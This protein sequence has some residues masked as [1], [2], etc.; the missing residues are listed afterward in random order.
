MEKYP[1]IPGR[2]LVSPL[3]TQKRIDFLSD[4]DMVLQHIKNHNLA[5]RDIQNKIESFVGS[6]EVP[7]GLIGPIQFNENGRSE[8]IYSVA[9]TLEGALVASINRGAKAITLSGGFSADFLHQR[10]ER[11]PM[12][13][14]ANQADADHFIK[15]CT[16]KFDAIKKVAESHSNHAKLKE[17]RPICIDKAVHLKFLYT[18]G[19]A[20]GQNMTTTCTW[21]AVK[22]IVQHFYAATQILIE[23][24]L[25][26]GNGSSDKK[27]SRYILEEGRGSCVEASCFLSDD[28]IQKVLRT[29]SERLVLFYEN[30]IKMAQESGMLGFN[31]NIANVI[32]ALFLA[33]GQDM[34]SVHESSLGWFNVA[35]AKNGVSLS[36]KL[37]SLV[38]GSIGGGTGLP[39]QKEVLEL[40][41]CYGKGKVQRFAKCIAGFALALEISTFGAVV[42]GEFAKAHEKLGRNRP[43]DFLSPA[44]ID[45]E[46]VKS[47]LHDPLMTEHLKRVAVEHITLVENGML[48][49]LTART[50]KKIMGFIPIRLSLCEGERQTN[51][52]LL[53]KSK[54]LDVD[55]YNGLHK[56]ACAIDIKLAD[57]L[58]AYRK[59]LEYHRCHLKE[60]AIYEALAESGLDVSPKFYDKKIDAKREIYV[61][62]LEF[63][64]KENLSIYDSENR[65]D[66]WTS[67]CIEK[68]ITTL[69]W[70]H[71]KLYYAHTKGR[72]DSV[73]QFEVKKALPFYERLIRVV[74]EEEHYSTRAIL[75][76]ELSKYLRDLETHLAGLKLPLTVIHNDFNPRNIAIRKDGRLAIYDW[77]LS[78]VNLPHRDVVELL[79][80]VLPEDFGL[81]QME[82]YLKLHHH[83]A[84]GNIPWNNW[85]QGYQRALKEYLV[86]RVLFYKAAN[87]VM[88]LKFIDRVFRCTRRMLQLLND[89]P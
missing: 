11:A 22:W 18:T 8:L 41:G 40:M 21:H 9:A 51:M 17:I 7:V 54:G 36:L 50:T 48:S 47:L 49:S 81:E 15:W 34:A 79:S 73:S 44:D 66:L 45:L 20:S 71:E 83:L 12:F 80:F 63:L 64:E 74:V 19:D 35:K 46:F 31:I 43:I 59:Q 75:D 38:I 67:V 42:S 89:N 30:S 82:R 39:A 32:A 26:D 28:V 86:T 69:T 84:G 4:N 1:I 68:A 56:V 62:L 70:V 5:Y 29:T 52:R 37:P 76:A 13:L 25:I 57:A 2:G 14:L 65:P 77:E 61:L 16:D 87:V 3:A 58:Y 55:V 33:T 85:K 78:V 88:K 53:L 72:L 10:M 60:I 6:V 27:V 24:Y 23:N